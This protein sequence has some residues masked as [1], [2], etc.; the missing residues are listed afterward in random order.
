MNTPTLT[1]SQEYN[2]P[3]NE[4]F[5]EIEVNVSQCLSSTQTIEIPDDLEYDSAILADY[6]R[7]QI[8]LPS[9]YLEQAK[10]YAWYIDDFCINI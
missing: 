7:D 4:K 9:D 2:A 6:V 3:W 1:Q 8:M 10:D 5:K